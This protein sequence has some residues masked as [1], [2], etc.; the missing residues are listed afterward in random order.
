MAFSNMFSIMNL[1]LLRKTY[2]ENVASVSGNFNKVLISFA[3][4]L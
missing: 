1:M 4:D 3:R 2:Y